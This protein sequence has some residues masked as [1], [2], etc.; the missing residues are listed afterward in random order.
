MAN[1][2]T[3]VKPSRKIWEADIELDG[4]ENWLPEHRL[5]VAAIERALRDCVNGRQTGLC[6]EDDERKSL[7]WLRSNSEETFSFLWCV[8]HLGYGP[9][10]VGKARR[11]AAAGVAE[12]KKQREK[13]EG[14]LN[15]EAT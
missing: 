14:L 13:L 12:L 10:F 15:E 2:G 1:T 9:D 3:V 5:L 7:W 6:T 8:E 4:R 11:L